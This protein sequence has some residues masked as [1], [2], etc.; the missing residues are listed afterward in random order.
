MNKVTLKDCLV[1]YAL[2]IAGWCSGYAFM[3]NRHLSDLAGKS[4]QLWDVWGLEIALVKEGVWLRFLAD[5]GWFAVSM[6][7][8]M[9][10][11][12]LRNNVSKKG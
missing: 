10:I 4:K 3:L 5:F 12:F 2:L 9:L 1:M 8:G 6:F 7:C 11:V